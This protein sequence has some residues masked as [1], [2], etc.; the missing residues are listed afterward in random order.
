MPAASTLSVGAVVVGH[1]APLSY[2]LS[3]APRPASSYAFWAMG[4]VYFESAASKSHA[5]PRLLSWLRGVLAAAIAHAEIMGLL[6]AASA[7]YT[8]VAAPGSL[9]SEYG[10]PRSSARR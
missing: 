7:A 10:P 3:V 4:C 9:A 8:A 6:F 1:V 2:A 5:G